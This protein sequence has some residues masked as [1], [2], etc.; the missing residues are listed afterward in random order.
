[1][2]VRTIDDACAVQCPHNGFTSYRYLL[3]RDGMGFSVH[4]T[5]IP[6]GEPQFWHYTNHQEACYCVSGVGE[7]INTATGKKYMIRPGTL[8]ALDQ[9]DPHTFQAFE[10]VVLI[11]VFNPPVRGHEVHGPDGSYEA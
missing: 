4:K 8:Y 2:K 10:E 11:S 7:L 5:V 9:H 6:A 1:M 3:E